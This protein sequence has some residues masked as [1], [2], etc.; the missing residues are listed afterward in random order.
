[1][2]IA[3]DLEVGVPSKDRTPPWKESEALTGSSETPQTAQAAVSVLMLELD[4]ANEKTHKDS[5][6]EDDGHGD[7]DDNANTWHFP[8][9]DDL[10]DNI[11]DRAT[12]T[13]PKRKKKKQIGVTKKTAHTHNLI[14]S[15]WDAVKHTDA[16]FSNPAKGVLVILAT[17][18]V[19]SRKVTT[20]EHCRP[21][22]PH[23]LEWRVPLSTPK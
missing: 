23:W 21:G 2:S 20:S 17:P 5:D 22:C 8:D 3:G 6:S 7:S 15:Q 14:V 1:M 10:D 11:A 18:R 9:D 12:T 16:S 19:S 13:R 4:L